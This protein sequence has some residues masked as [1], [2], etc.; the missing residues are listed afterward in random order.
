MS[1]P[2]THN[3]HS[4][5]ISVLAD[6]LMLT[7]SECL[8]GPWCCIPVLLPLPFSFCPSS[9]YF[10]HS[11]FALFHIFFSFFSISFGLYFWSMILELCRSIFTHYY[12]IFYV[13]YEPGCLWLSQMYECIWVYV[14]VYWHA[15]TL[16]GSPSVPCQTQRSTYS[17]S[18]DIQFITLAKTLEDCH[19]TQRWLLEITPRFC[20]TVKCY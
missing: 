12:C 16:A 15:C 14:C 7:C 20:S 18:L 8:L 5:V 17:L 2:H 10:I 4:V 6:L 13:P 11:F 9:P 1:A 3:T 19:S